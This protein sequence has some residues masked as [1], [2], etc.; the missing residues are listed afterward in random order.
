MEG[1]GR[2][3]PCLKRPDG[4]QDVEAEDLEAVPAVQGLHDKS[5]GLGMVARVQEIASAGGILGPGPARQ[6]V[7]QIPAQSPGAKE[8]VPGPPDRAHIDLV[9]FKGE[10]GRYR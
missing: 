10:N 9:R 6:I 7:Q 1:S 4:R 8:E 5:L 2:G 3:A